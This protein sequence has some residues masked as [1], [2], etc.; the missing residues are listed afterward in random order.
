MK[1]IA[2]VI[3][4]FLD[5][6][7]DKVLDLKQTGFFQNSLMYKNNPLDAPTGVH[8]IDKTKPER[9]SKNR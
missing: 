2:R 6:S 3:T 8:N 1:F 5:L 9:H 7:I 4:F